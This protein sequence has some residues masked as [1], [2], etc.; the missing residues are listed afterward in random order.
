LAKCARISNRADVQQ[1]RI[2]D[3]V[4]RKLDEGHLKCN[5][6]VAFFKESNRVGIE[7]CVRDDHMRLVKAIT[8]W[9]APLLDV[10]EG[11]AL[12]LLY[13]IRWAKEQNFNNVIF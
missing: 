4:W 1:H 7:I 5:V 2:D 13:A 8:S 6:D 11:E 9:S 3:T 12:G 10:F